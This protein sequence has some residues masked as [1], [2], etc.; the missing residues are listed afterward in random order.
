MVELSKEEW[1]EKGRELYGKD[2]ED[3]KFK[4]PNCGRIQSAS[5]IREQMKKGEKSQRWGMLKK[6]D[7]FDPATSCFSPSC[8]WVSHGLFS[9]GILVIYDSSKPHD[10]SLKKNCTY[11]F[12]FA[13]FN[14]DEVKQR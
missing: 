4:C 9:T 11:V 2:M 14:W 8:N 12:P 3:W 10:A 7:D 13:D 5:S 1:L 6:G